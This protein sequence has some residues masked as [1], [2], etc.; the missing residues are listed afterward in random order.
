MEQ[1]TENIE[2]TQLAIIENS[3]ELFR[4]APEILKE[5]RG[6]SMKAVS[7]GNNI[8]DQ[9]A[10]AWQIE[11]ESER[12]ASLFA[13]GERSKNFLANCSTANKE[14]KE[15]RAALTQMM[16]EFKKLFTSAENELDK[17]KSGSL[18]SKVQAERDKHVAEIHKIEERKRREAELKAAKAKEAIE[19]R[20]KIENALN[21]R[22]YD[23]LSKAQAWLQ[24]Q[25]NN[26]S[27]ENFADDAVQIRVYKPQLRKDL[28][29][30]W[31]V[32]D[33]YPFHHH[34]N[35][36]V[37]S[38]INDLKTESLYL[39]YAE[40]YEAK[41]IVFRNELVDKIPSKHEELKEQKRLSD[42]AAEAAKKAAQ[43]KTKAAKEAAEKAAKEAADRAKQA[44]EDRKKREA[45]DAARMA[46]EA[47]EARKKAEEE[48][49]IKKHGEQTM[50]MFDQEAELSGGQPAPETRMGY[51]IEVLHPAGSVQI[52]QKWFEDEGKNLP[53][54]KIGK[55]KMDQMKAYCEKLAQ[56]IG[57]KIESKFLKYNESFK[58]INRK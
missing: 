8:L 34:T 6:R 17:S 20:N 54:D 38:F 52:F 3:I 7:V 36:E 25:F 30:Q 22:L 45:A 51:D 43:A 15:L 28:F 39:S 4:T 47:E 57:E 23:H 19:I 10:E 27:L 14:M 31:A 35:E 42:E 55:T 49:E 53:V 16:D 37:R 2:N 21:D 50:V 13:I 1:I 48:A 29:D 56:K 41:M 44:D 46:A 32:G 26:I 40:S 11:D 5:N 24:N 58:A 9:W 12:M 33:S 18:A